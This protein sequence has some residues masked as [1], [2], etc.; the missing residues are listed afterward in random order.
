MTT[1]DIPQRVAK[2]R[3]AFPVSALFR[4]GYLTTV[5]LVTIYMVARILTG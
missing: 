5:V 3:K 1:S 2:E 4:A